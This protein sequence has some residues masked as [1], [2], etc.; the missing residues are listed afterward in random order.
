MSITTK[1]TKK[2]TTKTARK[3]VAKKTATKSVKTKAKSSTA[4]STKTKAATKT[5]KK[6]ATKAKSA[7]TKSKG[8]CAG[9][10]CTDSVLRVSKFVHRIDSLVEGKSTSEPGFGTVKCV[11][12]AKSSNNGCRLFEVSGSKVA[13]NR[14]DYTFSKLMDAMGIHR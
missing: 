9:G 13:R 1:K 5:T 4:K 7:K 6:T 8:G 2:T 10:K 14:S 3:T 11:K 12:S